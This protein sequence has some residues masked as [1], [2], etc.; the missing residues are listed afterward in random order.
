MSA[1]YILI[2]NELREQ[3]L[4]FLEKNGG[5]EGTDW[6]DEITR[7]PSEAI[8]QNYNLAFSGGIDKLRYR[9]SFG[10]M[11]Q[12]GIL[13]G[14]DYERLSGRLNLDSELTKWLNVSTNFNVIYEGRTN[15]QENDSYTATVFST[16]AADPITPVYRNNLIDVPDFLYDRIYNGYEPTNEWSKY[17]GVLYSSPSK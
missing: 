2:A 4:S 15:I 1:K 8:N 16:A 6:W 7:N 9:S 17:T 11:N 3:I 10:Y 13:R 14:S 5:R 12:Q